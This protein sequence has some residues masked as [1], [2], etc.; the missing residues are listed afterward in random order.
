MEYYELLVFYQVIVAGVER[1][2]VFKCICSGLAHSVV[3]WK[4]RVRLW[5]THRP[6][7]QI[8]NA[9]QTFWECSVSLQSVHLP[10]VS[11]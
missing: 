11:T 8:E 9:I 5:V 7:G 3:Y 1:F 2:K 10:P 4:A 6:T